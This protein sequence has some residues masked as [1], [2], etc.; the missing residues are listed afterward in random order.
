MSEEAA[1][2]SQRSGDINDHYTLGKVVGKGTFA[3]VQECTSKD[4]GSQWAVKVFEK[5]AMS[6]KENTSLKSEILI[7]RKVKHSNVVQLREIFDSETHFYLV[8]ERM[9][10]GELFDRIVEK[11]S[12]VYLS[13]PGRR[14]Q[15]G[16]TVCSPRARVRRRRSACACDADEVRVR[17][18]PSAQFFVHLCV[19]SAP[20]SRYGG[21]MLLPVQ[22]HRDGRRA[23]GV[24]HPASAAALPQPGHRASRPQAREPA[25]RH[26]G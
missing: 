14:W 11:L 19:S 9:H 21:A 7:L 20:C 1:N 25:V 3:T 4:D 15:W 18:T 10:G 22:V 24:Q 13:Q 16:R 6:A 2:N 12:C 17:A 26:Q 8:M 23:C 5:A